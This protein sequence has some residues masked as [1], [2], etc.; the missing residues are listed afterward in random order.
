MTKIHLNH[1]LVTKT[2]SDRGCGLLQKNR[3]FP[4]SIEGNNDHSARK[5]TIGSSLEALAAG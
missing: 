4:L 1:I 5:A 3:F 2:G